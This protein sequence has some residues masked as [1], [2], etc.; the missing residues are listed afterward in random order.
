MLQLL[1]ANH[2]KVS[3]AAAV[4][5]ALEDRMDRVSDPVYQDVVHTAV[6]LLQQAVIAQPTLSVEEMQSKG[7]T[8]YD[9]FYAEVCYSMFLET[10]AYLHC[11][12]NVLCSFTQNSNAL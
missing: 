8:P 4:A 2:A 3:F 11:Y 12:S 1:L 7:L 6:S 9:Q 5:E 10:T